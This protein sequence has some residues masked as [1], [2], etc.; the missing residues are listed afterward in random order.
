[1]N[2]RFATLSMVAVLWLTGCASN[3]WSDIPP[4]EADEWK[5]I[6]IAAHSAN[7]FRQ[8]GFTPTDI[9]P[10]VQSGIQSPDTIMSW[11]REG[12][13]PQETAKWQAKGFTLPRA[14]EL[15]KQGL[16]VQ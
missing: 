6:G 7:L 11:H 1:M 10:W 13:T 16:T 3:P 2:K 4:Q 5:G 9:K 15:R 8:S 14:I 12:F